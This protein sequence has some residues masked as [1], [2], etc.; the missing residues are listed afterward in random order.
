METNLAWHLTVLNYLIHAAVGGSLVLL[1]GVLAARACRQPVH[2]VRLI[3]L[4]LLGSLL[5]P[6]LARVSALPH[7]SVGWLSLGMETTT[8][9]SS[10]SLAAL[11]TASEVPAFEP[12]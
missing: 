9:A 10:E 5:V 6:C 8:T 3:E 4:T 12:G 2:R 7:L 11:A 1:A